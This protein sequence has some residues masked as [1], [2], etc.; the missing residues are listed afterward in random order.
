MLF[1]SKNN[2]LAELTEYQH[3]LTRVNTNQHESG[4]YQQESTRAQHESE[5]SQRKSTKVRYE[6][7]SNLRIYNKLQKYLTRSFYLWI[8][9]SGTMSALYLTAKVSSQILYWVCLLFTLVWF[10]HLIGVVTK[11]L[12]NVFLIIEHILMMWRRIFFKKLYSLFFM[13][14]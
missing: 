6:S 11:R 3:N 7:N 8:F 2:S 1:L 13:Q 12:F 14:N 9:F 5:T 4:T 10:L